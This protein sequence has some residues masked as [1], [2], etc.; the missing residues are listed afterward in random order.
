MTTTCRHRATAASG[1]GA[2]LRLR[3]DKR[4]TIWK[5]PPRGGSVTAWLTG[6]LLGPGTG[7]TPPFGANG[8]AFTGDFSTMDMANTAFH[9]IV[10]I[11]V[12]DNN[13]TLVAGTPSLL[14]TG[15]NA[16]DGI[17]IDRNGFIWICANQEDEIVVTDRKGGINPLTGQKIPKVIAKLGD[18]YGI[19]RN[20][21]AQG[22]LFP[23]SPALR[24]D[25]RTFYVSTLTLFLPMRAPTSPSIR[26]GRC[27]SRGGVEN[28]GRAAAACRR[29][30]T[31]IGRAGAARR[32]GGAALG[33]RRLRRPAGQ[34]QKPRSSGSAFHRVFVD[35]A[36]RSAL[37]RRAR[38][39]HMEDGG[40]PLWDLP[41]PVACFNASKAGARFQ[42]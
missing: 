41:V 24:R 2:R 10:Q 13:G 3:R 39:P 30:A 31:A 19:D 14:T 15:S 21:I 18:F 42:Q 11:P 22:C 16:P 29:D 4:R 8:I 12:T 36:A 37:P 7:L 34:R 40:S 25:G 6:P 9:Q 32:A 1:R 17:L 23:A 26:R 33:R 38:L 5:V 35:R 28:V 27:R 20:G